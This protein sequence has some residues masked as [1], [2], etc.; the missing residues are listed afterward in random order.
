MLHKLNCVKHIPTY[1][2]NTIPWSD[3]KYYVQYVYFFRTFRQGKKFP[4]SLASKID[5]RK[6]F[7]ISYIV[8]KHFIGLKNENVLE[9]KKYHY[10]QY[11]LN[12]NVITLKMFGTNR[13][14][15][16]YLIPLLCVTKKLI[17]RMILFDN[18]R[19]IPVHNPK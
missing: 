5:S 8:S 17:L 12:L 19:I 7:G 18:L 15:I 16:S 14:K 6:C 11:F 2:F 9:N 10:E 4:N 3:L 1:Y 13:C